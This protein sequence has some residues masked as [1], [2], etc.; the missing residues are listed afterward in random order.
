MPK[1]E[2][3]LRSHLSQAE[4]ERAEKIGD[5]S[6]KSHRII[7]MRVEQYPGIGPEGRAA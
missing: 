7:D 6:F 3:K 1:T 5:L 4:R 2:R